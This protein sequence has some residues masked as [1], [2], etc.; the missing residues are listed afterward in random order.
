MQS[1]DERQCFGT[2][3][4]TP[5]CRE[6]HAVSRRDAGGCYL[7]IMELHALKIYKGKLLNP[8]VKLLF[9]CLRV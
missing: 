7:G 3:N 6:T 5:G 4:S 1:A 2:S 8:F 9:F